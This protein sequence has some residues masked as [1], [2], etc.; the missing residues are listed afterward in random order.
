MTRILEQKD[1]EITDSKSIV[2]FEIKDGSF[3]RYI[4]IEGK[5]AYE[6]G[7][8]CGT[9][10]FYFKRLEGANQKVQPKD[11]IEQLNEGIISLDKKTIEIFAE[12]IP[13]G[14]YKVLLLKVYPKKI[15]LGTETDYFTNEQLKLFRV[16]R[17]CR[18]MH[19]PKIKYYRGTDQI[20]KKDEKIF[21]FLIPIFPQNWLEPKRVDFYKQQFEQEKIP[22][23]ISLSI[24]DNKSPATWTDG[25][26]PEFTRH[27]CLAH[28]I[29]DGHH[30][31]FAAAE[32][33]KPIN[34]FC[35]LAKE[36]GVFETKG[37]IEILLSNI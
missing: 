26:R 10:N 29:L 12:I 14:K 21:E 33:K 2:S 7:L 18:R 3:V 15:E 5:H 4:S 22:T 30:K 23:A 8:I 20:I 17:F 37:D 24:L 16:D 27:W 11:L 31:M 28:Y 35:F 6:I 9:C 32:L 13:N 25:Q 34:L 1:L 19:K 36:E